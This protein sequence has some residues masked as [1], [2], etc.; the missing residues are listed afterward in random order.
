MGA[1]ARS[2]MCSLRPLHEI[3]ACVHAV[4]SE[5]RGAC[6]CEVVSLGLDIWPAE[7]FAVAFPVAV[8]LGDSRQAF[9]VGCAWRR[10]GMMQVIVSG[11]WLCCSPA[12]YRARCFKL[13]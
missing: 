2:L 12:A 7:V 5:T 1:A 6:V 3:V 9:G 13:G 11:G 10:A 8:A 4:A